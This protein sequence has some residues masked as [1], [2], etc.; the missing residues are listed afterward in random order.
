M[1]RFL[2]G[3]ALGCLLLVA[4]QLPRAAG[5]YIYE[6]CTASVNP[7]YCSAG[8]CRGTDKCRTG[9]MNPQTCTCQP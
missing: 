1:V 4:T 3:F 8:I 6:G 9:I 2:L 5:E 7:P